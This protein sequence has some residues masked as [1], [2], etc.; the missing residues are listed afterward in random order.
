M[1]CIQSFQYQRTPSGKIIDVRKGTEVYSTD[2]A[3]QGKY[4]EYWA[5]RDNHE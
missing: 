1:R 4:R 3:T 5:E 2:P